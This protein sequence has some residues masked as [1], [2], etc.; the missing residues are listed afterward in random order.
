MTKAASII[1]DLPGVDMAGVETKI[2]P[3]ES[4]V[5]NDPSY[6][7][8]WA[9]QKRSK[10]KA[11]INVVPVWEEFTTGSDKVIVGVL[12]EGLD[13]N[14]PDLSS[15]I[16]AGG[17]KGSKNFCEDNFNIVAERHGTHVGGIIGAKNN[18]ATGVCGV[19]GGN[20]KLGDKGVRLL[21]CQIFQKNK[22]GGDRA[23][24]IVWA[25][26]KG[27]VI[28]NNSWSYVYKNPEEAQNA[29]INFWDKRAVDYFIENAGKDKDGNQ[30]G[31]MAGGVVFFSAGNNGWPNSAPGNYDKVIA[32]GNMTS[33]LKRNISSNYGDWVDIAA[34]GT[35]IKS[36]LSGNSYGNLTGTSMS[37]PYVSG[38]AAL[39]VSY[40]GGPGF[41]NERLKEKLLG[42]ADSKTLSPDEKIGPM[43]DAMEAFWYGAYPPDKVADLVLEA[44]GQSIKYS[45]KISGDKEKTKAYSYLAALSEN[46]EALKAFNPSSS[47]PLPAGII[48]ESLRTSGLRLGN[49]LSGKFNDLGY[50]KTYFVTVAGRTKDGKYGEKSEIKEIRT[51]L[52]LP[53]VI[54]PEKEGPFILGKGDVI[55]IR[56]SISDPEKHSCSVVFEAG[57]KA[58]SYESSGNIVKVK[59]DAKEAEA[60]NYTAKIIVKDEYGAETSFE[61]KYSIFDNFSPEAVKAF[62]DLTVNG[63][64]FHFDY[65][66][67]EYFTDRDNDALSYTASCGE[68]SP[69]EASIKGDVLTLTSVSYGE[70]KVEVAATDTHGAV[71]KTSFKVL[72]NKPD[73]FVQVYP[74]PVR[75]KLNIKSGENMRAHI[76]I[77]G[78]IGKIVYDNVLDIDA[79]SPASISTTSFSPGAYR[80]EISCGDKKYKNTIIKI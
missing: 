40:Y 29:T 61:I 60:G 63:L 20:Y 1:E 70:G 13:L 59:L 51:L 8:Q 64:G 79:S 45:F 53:P 26:D 6:P 27:A 58:A 2:S 34:P 3:N 73:F 71:F 46:K 56:Y 42:G 43:L 50:D 10:Q 69:V 32:V 75:D 18:N 48:I 4:Y 47:S 49:N 24:A 80:L 62:D 37:C 72:V 21:C 68:A 25:A 36:T 12:D 5:F 15:V 74:N 78:P 30:V 39:L 31:Q 67:Y 57:S 44:E 28:L 55:T 7:S 33:Y 65:N 76:K 35:N 14:H 19:A 38:V 16:I 77:F 9:L 11:S 54:T 52:N 23:K 17:E 66:L 41:T 22:K